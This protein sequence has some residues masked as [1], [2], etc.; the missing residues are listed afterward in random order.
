MGVR[1]R[2]IANGEDRREE[3]SATAIHHEGKSVPVTISVGVATAT[4]RPQCW[5]EKLV[6]RA[7]AAMYLAKRNGR[8]RVES[9]M[10]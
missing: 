10:V 5:I 4:P 2:V 3:V 9:S 6:Q 7:D 1:N 8:N